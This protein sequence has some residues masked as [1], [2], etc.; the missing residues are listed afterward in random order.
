MVFCRQEN[1]ETDSGSTSAV[2][3]PECFA[4]LSVVPSSP[5]VPNALNMD[6]TR[7]VRVSRP[8]MFLSPWLCWLRIKAYGVVWLMRVVV[9]PGAKWAESLSLL[10]MLLRSRR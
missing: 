4:G 8:S 1:Y 5:W 9:G 2:P 7:A 10:R 3:L 6:H